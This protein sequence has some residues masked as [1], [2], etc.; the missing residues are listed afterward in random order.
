VGVETKIVELECAALSRW[1]SGDP[2]G[3]LEISAPDVVYFDPYLERRLDGLAALTERYEGLRGMIDAPRFEMIAPVVQ[4]VGDA[5]ILTFNFNSWD[6]DGRESRW[7]CTEAYRRTADGWRIFQTHWSYA[8]AGD[9]APRC[10]E[11]P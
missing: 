9:P 8:N 2:S 11:R 7:N 1:C 6:A 4:V 5:A 3:F 10:E